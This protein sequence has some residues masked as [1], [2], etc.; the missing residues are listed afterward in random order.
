MTNF[1]YA[2]MNI[3]YDGLVANGL[4][5]HCSLTKVVVSSF[6]EPLLVP[7][8]TL[9]FGVINCSHSL[10]A[11]HI[12]SGILRPDVGDDVP[13]KHSAISDEI[14]PQAIPVVD[15]FDCQAKMVQ[16]ILLADFEAN[17]VVVGHRNTRR[18]TSSVHPHLKLS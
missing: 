10:G 17:G 4:N 13:T 14:P 16:V 8:E 1:V 9:G 2:W 18:I 6:Q 7:R 3:R 5:L 12:P 15:Q 11:G